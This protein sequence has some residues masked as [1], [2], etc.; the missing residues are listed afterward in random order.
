M[1]LSQEDRFNLEVLRLLLQLAW[2]DGAVDPKELQLVRGLGRS[3][4]VPEPELQALVSAVEKGQRP[5]EPDYCLLRDRKDEV[6]M[7]ARALVAADGVV[8]REETEL[9][10]RITTLLE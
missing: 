4:T 9:L 7:A 2:S 5:A 8:R 3:W 6:L 1:A 10:Q